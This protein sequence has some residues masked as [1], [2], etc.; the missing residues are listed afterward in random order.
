MVIY[1]KSI[2]ATNC[3]NFILFETAEFT[4]GSFQNLNMLYLVFR[5]KPT[6]WH[7][8]VL[9]L[10]ID[11]FIYT[12]SGK[13]YHDSIGLDLQN[14]YVNFFTKVWVGYWLSRY[15]HVVVKIFSLVKHW[16][17]GFRHFFIAKLRQV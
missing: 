9:S 15:Y 11:Q 7:Y 14:N 10:R 16:F 6:Q 13:V 17:S 8:I 12:I 2:N 4:T 1:M 5:N 3:R